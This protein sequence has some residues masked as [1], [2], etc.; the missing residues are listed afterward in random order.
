[1]FKSIQLKLDFSFDDE[2]QKCQIFKVF[3]FLEM[4]YNSL[5]FKFQRYFERFKNIVASVKLGISPIH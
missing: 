5:F 2:Y 1:M 4:I 3:Y